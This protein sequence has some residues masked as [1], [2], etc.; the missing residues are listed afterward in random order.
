MLIRD[1][2]GY[3]HQVPDRVPASAVPASQVVY[4]GLGNPV[5]HLGDF[6]DIVKSVGGA[7]AAPFTAP[8]QAIGQAVAPALPAIGQAIGQALPAVGSMLTAPLTAPFA[9]PLQAISGLVG[10]LL[11][12][13]A[14]PPAPG[15]PM[16]PPPPA[17][18]YQPGFQVPPPGPYPHPF[19]PR[20]PW[21]TGWI[22]APLPYTG[23]G[24]KRVYMRCAVW[25]GDAGLV[26]E[27]AA[28]A[29]P[30][31][32]VAPG[33]PGGPAAPSPYPAFRQFRRHFR[34]RRR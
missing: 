10:G 3:F 17:M 2:F 33:L 32:P 8:L 11:P 23:L 28:H 1:N 21:P 24:P 4:D 14:M 29:Q 27:F 20:T 26:P 30:A 6:W 12:H 9:G 25:P 16:A 15:F 13:P 7:I 5:G 18:A 19:P 22:Q 34:H 31:G